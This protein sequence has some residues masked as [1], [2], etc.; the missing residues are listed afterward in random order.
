MS[1]FLM[2]CVDGVGKWRTVCK[3][4]NGHDDD[5]LKQINGELKVVKIAK[6]P[7]KCDVQHVQNIQ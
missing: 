6:D 5:T 7:A 1:I 2:G 4:G 3:V